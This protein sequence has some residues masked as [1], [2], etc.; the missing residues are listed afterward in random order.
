M[1]LTRSYEPKAH[2][3]QRCPQCGKVCL[4]FPHEDSPQ[5]SLCWYQA[6]KRDRAIALLNQRA[7]LLSPAVLERILADLKEKTP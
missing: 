4:P 1:I 3:L 2:H 7:L 6:D 5:C